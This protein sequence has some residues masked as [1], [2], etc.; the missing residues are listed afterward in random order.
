MNI[1]LAMLLLMGGQGIASARIGS[2]V[3]S[4]TIAQNTCC[5][6]ST[7][8]DHQDP[9]HKIVKEGGSIHEGLFTVRHIKKDWY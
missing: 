2:S 5:P 3:K 1:T 8:E 6:D 4:D 9:Y 7:I